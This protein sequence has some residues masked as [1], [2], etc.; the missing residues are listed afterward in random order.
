MILQSVMKSVVQWRSQPKNMGG[1]MFGF[2]RITLFCLEKRLSKHKMIFSKNF[3]GHGHFGPPWLRLCR[4][5]STGVLR[6]LKFS[7]RTRPALAKFKPARPRT[8]RSLRN[9][10]RTRPADHPNPR[11]PR[12][13]SV[14][15]PHL[16]ENY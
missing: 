2:R 5:T 15:N 9:F 12:T 4:G 6:G 8:R 1:K 10:A 3:G 13:F 7:V 16:S 11:P 14:S